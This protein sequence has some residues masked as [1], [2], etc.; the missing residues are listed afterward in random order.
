MGSKRPVVGVS[1]AGIVV[2]TPC[3]SMGEAILIFDWSSPHPLPVRGY[4]GQY[5]DRIET[6]ITMIQLCT[7]IRGLFFFLDGVGTLIGTG[8]C[9]R[10]KF[11]HNFMI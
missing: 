3:D 9:L 6:F 2:T 1:T 4:L 7:I 5:T 11:S 8:L 10:V